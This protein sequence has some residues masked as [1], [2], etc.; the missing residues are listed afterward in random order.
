MFQ[1]EE[2]G[3]AVTITMSRSP[4]NAISNEWLE[5]FHKV[6][7]A[8]EGRDSVSVV[9]IRS[10]QRVFCAGADLKQTATRFD[11]GTDVWVSD[12]RAIH[13]V[14]DRIEAL[15]C[16]T[17][18]EIHGAALGGGFELAL[19][20]DLRI[21]AID[22]KIGLPEARLGLIP[23]AGGTQ[24]LTRLCGPGVASR[25]IL[26][27]EVVDG[28]AACAL[29]MV[30]WAVSPQ[31]LPARAG[32]IRE[33]IAG[34]SAPALRVSKKC[35]HAQLDPN[36]NGFAMEIDSQRGLI[37][38]KEARSRVSAFLAERAARQSKKGEGQ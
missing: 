32:A 12:V 9:H 37:T 8:A 11:M 31:E 34:L 21:A 5:N 29:G 25:I 26:G 7:D 27:C 22:A 2:I 19:S 15:P 1:M 17:L 14:F 38:S 36:S 16:V 24:R 13:S 23:G 28:A 20:C 18:A 35:I 30:Q 33:R 3:Q 4:V 6:L 10:D